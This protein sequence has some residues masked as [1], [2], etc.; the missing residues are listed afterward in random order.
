MYR[1]Y[2]RPEI[3]PRSSQSVRRVSF[4]LR[5]FAFLTRGRAMLA[6]TFLLTCL[7]VFAAPMHAEERASLHKVPP[8]YPEMAKRMHITGSVKVIAT[9]DAA[10]GVS[11]AMSDSGNKVLAQAAIDAVKRWKFAPGD[12]SA[13]VV[14]QI[15]FDM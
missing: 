3:S 8:I 15:N 7:L 13:T 14:V 11:N 6:S 12:G 10:G 4:P 1:S 9:V 2:L 5:S